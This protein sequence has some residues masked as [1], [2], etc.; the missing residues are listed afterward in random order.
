MPNVTVVQTLRLGTSW[1]Q[2]MTDCVPGKK[3]GGTNDLLMCENIKKEA[4]LI[5][6]SKCPIAQ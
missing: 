3:S 2:F 4:K 6:S 1:I 5:R